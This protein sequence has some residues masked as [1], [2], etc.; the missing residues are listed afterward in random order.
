V[1]RPAKLFGRD[2]FMRSERQCRRGVKGVESGQAVAACQGQ[3][4]LQKRLVPVR[5]IGNRLEKSPVEGGF[6]LALMKH[7]LGKDLEPH[8]VARRKRPLVVVEKLHGLSGDV[9]RSTGGGDQDTGIDEGEDQR[10]ASPRRSATSFSRLSQ[11]R[12]G[13]PERTTCRRRLQSRRPSGVRGDG[14]SWSRPGA[15]VI[16]CWSFPE[17]RMIQ[18]YHSA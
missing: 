17:A 12:R 8:E 5:P 13:A 10:P 9:C 14:S 16:F 6:L 3:R 4:L 2:D 18:G 15:G 1:E 11:S 7:R